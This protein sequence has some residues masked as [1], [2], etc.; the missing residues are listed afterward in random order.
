MVNLN[1]MNISSPDFRIWQH[2]ED[3]INGTQLHH[4]VNIPSVPID[5][6]YKHMV[7]SNGPITQLTSTDESIDDTVSLW[8]LFSH[9]RIYVTAI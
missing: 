9:T 8:T 1:M 3:N 4:F 2:L 7:S 5:Y 6:L